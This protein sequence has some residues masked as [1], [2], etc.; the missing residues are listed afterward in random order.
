MSAV[1]VRDLERL[2][3]L[4][5]ELE[6]LVGGA[7]RLSQCDGRMAW[8]R[9]GVY[10]FREPGEDRSDTGA[11]PRIVR[12]GTHALNAGSGTSLWGR[13]SQHRGTVRSGGG[14]HRG[15]IFR[16]IVGTALLRRDER[17]CQTWGR[18]SSAPRDIREREQFLEGIVSRTIGAMPFLWLAVDDDPGPESL[19][20]YV[21]RNAIALLS[22]HGKAPID[23][24]SSAW[25]GRLCNR[26]LVRTSGLWNQRHVEESCDPAFLDTLERLVRRMETIA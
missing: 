17:Q 22:N 8:P 3:D 26:E 16:L 20:G 9:R 12:V 15:S 13:L 25:L 14:N 10:F 2:Y 6:R 1:R 18:G 7:R 19:R 5:D 21:E 23:P 24:P 11:G 4:L